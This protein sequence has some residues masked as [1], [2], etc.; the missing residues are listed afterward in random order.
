MRTWSSR[1]EP[2]PPILNGGLVGKL[3]VGPEDKLVEGDDRDRSE[4]APVEWDLGGKRQH[5]DQRIGD[6]HLVRIAGTALHV[7]QGL[8]ARGAA[9]ERDHHRLLHQVIFLD[10]GLHHSR[11]LIGGPAGTCGDHDLDRL[12]R[13]PCVGGSRG[14]RE[15]GKRARENAEF[16]PH[17][18][19]PFL[20]SGCL[21]K[22]LGARAP[23]RS[24]KGTASPR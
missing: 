17:V 21:L 23:W 18:T 5:V 24:P 7:D 15:A 20:V 3:R 19:P 4:L 16:S 2:V 13:L 1:F 14:Q 6:Q 11:H 10:G 8:R 9:L 22:R 12:A